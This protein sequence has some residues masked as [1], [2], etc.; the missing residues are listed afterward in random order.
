MDAIVAASIVTTIGSKSIFNFASILVY[1]YGGNA[2]FL[3]S[4]SAPGT[5]YLMTIQQQVCQYLVTQVALWALY[6]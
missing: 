4:R 2:L 5:L 1:N 3:M 6:I